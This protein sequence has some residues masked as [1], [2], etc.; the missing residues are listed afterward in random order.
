MTKNEFQQ[1]CYSFL[2][3]PYKWGGFTPLEGLDCSGLVQELLKVI[4]ICP[5]GDNTAFDLMKHFESEGLASE[6]GTGSL[7]FFGLN[8]VASHIGIMINETHFIEAGGGGSAVN[9]IDIAKQKDARV[10]IRPLTNRKDLIKIIKPI[11][12][13]E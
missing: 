4:G 3:I 12:P 6:V 7:V 11:L 1:I 2:N 13:W 9:S 5:P 10:R 8:G